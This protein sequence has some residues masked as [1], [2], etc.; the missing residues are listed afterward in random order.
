MESAAAP[1]GCDW[2]NAPTH[3]TGTSPWE[4]VG[5]SCS[6][7]SRHQSESSED[8][9][10]NTVSCTLCGASATIVDPTAFAVL[11]S[12]GGTP[13]LLAMRLYNRAFGKFLWPAQLDI[14][15][16]RWSERTRTD[17]VL[18]QWQARLYSH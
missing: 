17:R 11:R 16:R 1:H 4:L 9:H 18:S 8:D 13:K 7:S 10:T 14:C 2:C 5:M 12:M 6:V 3:G 15:H